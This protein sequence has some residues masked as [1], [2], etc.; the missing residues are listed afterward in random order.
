MVLEDRSS[1]DDLSPGEESDD[2]FVPHASDTQSESG[3][4]IVQSG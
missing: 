1:E 4:N 2:N 3:D